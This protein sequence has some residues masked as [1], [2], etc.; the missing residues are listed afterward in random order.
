T[1]MQLFTAI[2]IAL[3]ERERSGLGQFVRTSYFETVAFLEWKGATF[4]QADGTILARG[5]STGP[6]ILPTCDGHIAFFYRDVDWPQVIELFGDDRLR[7]PKF[8]TIKG[9]ISHEPELRAIFEEHARN[10]GKH[11]LYHHA[12]ALGIPVGSVETIQDLLESE[13]YAARR[14]LDERNPADG[15]GCTQPSLPFTFNGR[16]FSARDLPSACFGRRDLTE[17]QK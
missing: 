1:G 9:R 7:N 8:D 5:K 6:M 14:F 13:Q 2:M 4:Y 3:H 15:D 17:V 16:R 10:L 12:Q 11:K